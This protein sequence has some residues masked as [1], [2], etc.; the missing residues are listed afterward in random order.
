M[1][2]IKLEWFMLH[3]V[4]TGKNQNSEAVYTDSASKLSLQ[5]F[6]SY[7]KGACEHNFTILKYDFKTAH[8]CQYPDLY[9]VSIN[10]INLTISS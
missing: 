6:N 4:T 10:F 3:P 7:I 5:M 8:S 2:G 9:I 1:T